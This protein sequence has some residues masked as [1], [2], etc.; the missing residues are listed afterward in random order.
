[1]LAESLVRDGFDIF[2]EDLVKFVV[3][4]RFRL[5][6]IFY[7]FL[8]QLLEDCERIVCLSQ[9]RKILKVIVVHILAEKRLKEHF[10]PYDTV[11]RFFRSHTYSANR[12]HFLIRYF[13][14]AWVTARNF[15]QYGSCI[16]LICQSSRVYY[17]DTQS[18]SNFVDV[19]SKS[20][21]IFTLPRCCRA[22]RPKNWTV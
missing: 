6:D 15:A 5:F 14:L 10:C 11:N 16:S 18:D 7:I 22:P 12:E 3:I 1:M 4:F 13:W 21:K 9:S 19:I 8:K 17:W 20:C 2:E